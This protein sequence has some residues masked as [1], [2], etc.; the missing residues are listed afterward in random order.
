MG[1][2][3][4]VLELGGPRCARLKVTNGVFLVVLHRQ[5]E[6]YIGQKSITKE[7]DDKQLICLQI[8]TTNMG[9]KV[10]CSGY[11]F[12]VELKQMATKNAFVSHLKFDS[13]ETTYSYQ[14]DYN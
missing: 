4:S 7:I 11:N 6:L 3:F 5:R 13:N 9:T 10:I 8:K 12:I 1:K 2:W 14:Y